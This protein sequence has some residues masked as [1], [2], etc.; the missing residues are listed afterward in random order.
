MEKLLTFHLDDTNYRKL[1]QIAHSLKIICE[2]VLDTSYNQTIE[3]L[4]SGK[5]NPLVAP[6]TGRVPAESLLLMCNL[7]DKHMDKLLAE[8]R[9]KNV[10][11]DYKAILTPTNQKWTVF[12]LMLEMYREKEAVKNSLDRK[13]N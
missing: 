6:V 9:K 5:I 13:I 11:F 1:E 10:P 3:A 2:K 8:L 4:A 12:Q 7:T